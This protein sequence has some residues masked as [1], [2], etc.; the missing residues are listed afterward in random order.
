M[1]NR[2]MKGAKRGLNR[3]RKARVAALIV[4]SSTNVHCGHL[5]NVRCI[6]YPTVFW[7]WL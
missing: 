1:H 6:V 7:F 2:V 5:A 3:L 4:Y